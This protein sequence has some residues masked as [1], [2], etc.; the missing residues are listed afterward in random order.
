VTTDAARIK[1]L[2]VRTDVARDFP[3]N[4]CPASR[5]ADLIA[6]MLLRRYPHAV[7]DPIHCGESIMATV[8]ELWETRT[9]LAR[10]RAR[11]AELEAGK[12]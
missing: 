12:P 7:E 11:I 1:S 9:E 4:T 10:A 5:H 6:D 2:R 3:A 8:A